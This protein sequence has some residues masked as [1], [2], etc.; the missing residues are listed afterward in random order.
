MVP[1][2]NKMEQG[3]PGSTQAQ[4]AAFLATLRGARLAGAAFLVAAFLATAFFAGALRGLGAVSYT[5]LDVYKR[6]VLVAPLSKLG[7]S[8]NLVREGQGLSLIHI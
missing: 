6:Q 4:R 7:F 1:C 2:N 8:G 5:H 3:V